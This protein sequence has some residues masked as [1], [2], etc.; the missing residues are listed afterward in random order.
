LKILITTFTYTPN[1]DGCAAA[2][3]VLARGLARRGH[4]VIVATEFHPHRLPDGPDAN[5]RVVQFKLTGT[6]N[7]RVGV[8]GETAAYQDFLRQ[9]DGDLII[10]EN[11]DAWCTMLA[12]P[13]LSQ[14]PAKKILISHGYTTHVWIPQ[15]KFPWGLGVWLGGL[16]LLFR[17]PW[18]L[19]RFDQLVVLSERRDFGR[20]L[21]HRM[22]R[23]TG[24]KKVSIIPNGA[25]A[26][27]FNDPA[28]P[29]LRKEFGIGP[30]L[31]LLCVANYSDRKNQMLAVRAFRRAQLKDATLVFVGS[32]FNDYAEQARRQ[33]AEL[34]TEFPA[35]RVVWLEKLTRAQ[36]CAA[37]CAAD[38][39]VLAAKAETQPI[40]LLEAMA[41]QTP[42]LST[43]T[44]CVSELPGGLVARSEDELV[45]KMRELA[46]SPALRQKLMAEGWAAC[47]QTYDWEQV[48][49]AYDRLITKVCGKS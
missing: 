15:P 46:S 19:R 3:A 16:P 24:F 1:A 4:E 6:S 27:E 11:W 32:E 26:R 41:S 20:F 29:D 22:A 48:V 33:D 35:G 34:Q 31:L 42:W 2:A 5:P 45:K 8:Q 43:D 12:E 37:Y 49:A 36:T 13:L 40:V 47:Q 28:L 21:D 44:G 23:W 9:F 30:G 17:S 18:L 39:F 38:L 7:W 10:F 14:L 25:F